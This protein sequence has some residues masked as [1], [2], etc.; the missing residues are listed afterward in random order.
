MFT[1]SLNFHY[2]IPPP[3]FNPNQHETLGFSSL[4]QAQIIITMGINIVI[5][6]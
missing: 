2:K 6:L 3:P 1:A 5:F 4:V